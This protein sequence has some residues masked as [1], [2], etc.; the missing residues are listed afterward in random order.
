VIS[1]YMR[2]TGEIEKIKRLLKLAR[3]LE[4]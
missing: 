2:E 4:K 3:E 1:V